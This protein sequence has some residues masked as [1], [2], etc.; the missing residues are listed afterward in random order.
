MHVFHWR[1]T[2]VP[3]IMSGSY[4]YASQ[5]PV[6][7][8]LLCLGLCLLYIGSLYFVEDLLPDTR[9]GES[10][11][12][13]AGLLVASLI[14]ILVA[15][16]CLHWFPPPQPNSLDASQILGLSF[17]LDSIWWDFLLPCLITV[18]LLA[19]LILANI[20]TS[21]DELIREEKRSIWSATIVHFTRSIPHKILESVKSLVLLKPA[22]HQ[23]L[24]FVLS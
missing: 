6:A 5:L 11:W 1:P 15:L 19:P 2:L 22:L 23:S 24:I 18:L 20:S 9:G 14:S 21:L 4:G 12:K 7:S 16:A 13:M 10:W 3:R 17:R 8:V